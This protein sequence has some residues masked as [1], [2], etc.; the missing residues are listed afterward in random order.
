MTVIYDGYGNIEY[1]KAPLP[2]IEAKE[3]RKVFF[4]DVSDMSRD[5]AVAVLNEVLLKFEQT[6]RTKDKWYEFLGYV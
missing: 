5:S 1:Y 3:D 4:I 6:P 2:P